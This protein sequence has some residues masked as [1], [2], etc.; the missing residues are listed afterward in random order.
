MELWQELD[1]TDKEMLK[2]VLNISNLKSK[3]A[4]CKREYN[5]AKAKKEL[6]LLAKGGAKTLLQDQAKGDEDVSLLEL[7][8]TIAEG[9]C[10]QNQEYINYLK[11]HQ[12][13]L[14]MQYAVEMGVSNG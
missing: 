7:K 11:R 5:M 14:K 3:Y 2:A 1:N 4:S 10:E 9:E 12:D 8:T 6:E 13:W